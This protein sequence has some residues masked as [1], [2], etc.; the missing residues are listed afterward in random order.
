MSDRIKTRHTGKAVALTNP[1]TGCFAITPS[2][3]VDL[4]E[5]PISIYVGTAG[6]LKVTMFDDSV[7]TYPDIAAGRHNLRAKRVWSTGTTA[8]GLVAEC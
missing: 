4:Q 6:A 1:I 8:T 3:T 7:V 2:N 5:I